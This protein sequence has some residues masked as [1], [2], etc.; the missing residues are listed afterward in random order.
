MAN[1]KNVTVTVKRVIPYSELTEKEKTDLAY[2]SLREELLEL[3]ATDES[4]EVRKK[5]VERAEKIPDRILCDVLLNN[6]NDEIKEK[7][8]KRI[9][10]EKIFNNWHQP[11]TFFEKLFA[12]LCEFFDVDFTSK[13]NAL[14]ADYRRQALSAI[15]L[16]E[17][18]YSFF[19]TQ[20]PLFKV[21]FADQRKYDESPR[22]IGWKF[23]FGDEPDNQELWEL[24]KKMAYY[25]YLPE[26]REA[27]LKK[28][29]LSDVEIANI[30]EMKKWVNSSIE[31]RDPAKKSVNILAKTLF[32]MGDEHKN[33][34]SIDRMNNRI[35]LAKTDD[36]ETIKAAEKA[37]EGMY[38]I[39]AFSTSYTKKLYRIE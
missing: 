30:K 22:Y 35:R 4:L 21:R 5:L 11:M 31:P 3:I 27:V 18:K 37:L 1:S 13:L 32:N 2:T 24:L 23:S 12:F 17:L 14:E 38:E 26:E 28:G 39:S 29:L 10:N 7:A 15:Y 16:Y 20:L 19:G 25:K 9:Y 6:D 34:A 8:R 33:K 36:L